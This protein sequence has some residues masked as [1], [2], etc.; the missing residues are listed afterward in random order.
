M[1]LLLP[2][3]RV[4]LLPLV[5]AVLPAAVFAQAFTPDAPPPGE[6]AL[7]K[8]FS[9]R[10][11]PE[12]T[13]RGRI[14]R[15]DLRGYVF[16]EHGSEALVYRGVYPETDV[17]VSEI[18]VRRD[19]KRAYRADGFAKAYSP[20]GR[21]GSYG[22]YREGR[23]EGPWT[24]VDLGGE[25]LRQ[26]APTTDAAVRAFLAWADTTGSVPEG[27]TV[28]RGS[29]A[30]GHREGT[31]TRRRGGYPV[32][33]STRYRGG[34]LQGRS[35]VY[36]TAGVL[37][38]AVRYED[39]EAAETLYLR[40]G[41]RLDPRAMGLAAAVVPERM[42]RFPAPDCPAGVADVLTD[43][44]GMHCWE[45]AM[46]QHIYSRVSYPESA[47]RAGIEGKTVVAFV[48]ERDGRISGARTTAFVSASVDAEARRIVREM[49]PWAPGEQDG[50]PAQMTFQLPVEF[51]LE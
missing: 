9:H 5:L 28:T 41:Y 49:P 20:D 1:P 50:E 38:A 34:R 46:L 30:D 24:F 3:M 26:R 2:R 14:I 45:G 17:L 19:S 11:A 31:W 47:R 15:G 18:P 32:S 10:L 25:R 37:V 43:P 7:G 42:A 39:G 23:A 13:A 36:D 16:A 22:V 12:L 33:D 29:Y 51:R 6:I 27:A 48:V 44:E 40:P 21:Q 4:R 8:R 35:A